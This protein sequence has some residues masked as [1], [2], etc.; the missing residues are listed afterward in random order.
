MDIKI[1]SIQSHVVSGTVGNKAAIFPLQ[2]LGFDVDF[3]N[4]VHFSNHTGYSVI[5]GTVMTGDQLKDIAYGLNENNLLTHDYVLTGYIGSQTFLDSVLELLLLIKNNNNNM[6]YICDPVLGDDGKC[7]VPKELIPIFAEKIVSK[8]YMITPNQFEAELLTNKII[9]NHNDVLNIL[10]DLHKL[11]PKI[12]VLT[13]AIIDDI[14]IDKLA[15]YISYNDNEKN[16]I[17]IKQYIIKKLSGH[18]TGTGDTTASLILG[19]INILGEHN[20]GEAF[21]K[22]LCTMNGIIKNT[23]INQEKIMKSNTNYNIHQAAELCVIKSKN[24]IENPPILDC[25]EIEEHEYFINL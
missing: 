7:Y 11:G 4:T 14:S 1:L 16:I 2:L 23:Q 8:A 9:K 22:V 6:K 5:K 3:I 20:F 19:W 18:Y 13:S 12:V 17:I 24:I 15:C 21:K 25:D 10:I